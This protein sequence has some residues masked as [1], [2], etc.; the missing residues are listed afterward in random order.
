MNTKRHLKSTSTTTPHT[1]LILVELKSDTFTVPWAPS[2]SVDPFTPI[3]PIPPFLYPRKVRLKNGRAGGASRLC[4]EDVKGWLRGMGDEEDPEKRAEGTGDHKCSGRSLWSFP[5]VLQGTTATGELGCLNLS[6]PG[7]SSK[8]SWIRDSVLSS[9]IL[10]CGTAG[11]LEAKLAQQLAYLKQ[12]PLYGIFIDLLKAYDAMDG[13]RFMEIMEGLGLGPT[14]DATES[15][16]LGRAEASVLQG[17]EALRPLR[18][19][20]QG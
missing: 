15:N 16:L 6:E 9:S 3:C 4:A 7:R 2:R 20:F 12:R 13:D 14:Y 17:R 11:I 1:H 10:L 8:A 18:R 5:K 19:A